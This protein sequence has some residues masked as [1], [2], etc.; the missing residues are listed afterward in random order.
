MIGHLQI[1]GHPQEFHGLVA[2]LV[3]FTRLMLQNHG[4]FL[5]MGAVV[6]S[7]DVVMVPGRSD[8]PYATVQEW[9]QILREELRAHAADPA[10]DAVAYCVDVKLTDTRDGAVMSAVQIVFEHRS[11]EALDAFF[12]YERT[13]DDYEYRQPMLRISARSFF[14]EPSSAYLH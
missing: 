3:P 12:P 10:C 4:A 9:L 2:A 6:S 5:P 13:G 1:I 8:A 14:E 11:G 7:G